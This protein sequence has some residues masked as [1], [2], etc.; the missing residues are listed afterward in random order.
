MIEAVENYLNYPLLLLFYLQ[1]DTLGDTVEAMVVLPLDPAF[2]SFSSGGSSDAGAAAGDTAAAAGDLEAGWDTS[3]SRYA[4]DGAID[5]NNLSQPLLAAQHAAGGEDAQNCEVHSDLGGV[6][7]DVR[8]HQLQRQVSPDLLMHVVD[9][10]AAGQRDVIG[11]GNY[12]AVTF[13]GAAVN[14]SS[15]AHTVDDA[16]GLCKSV[17]DGSYYSCVEGS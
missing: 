1:G 5:D 13:K 17:L 14:S 6:T 10:V 3:S 11:T 16:G 8:D 9:D 2:S 7:G 4:T 15:A 12:S